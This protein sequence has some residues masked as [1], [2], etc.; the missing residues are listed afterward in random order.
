MIIFE[1][2][3]TCS[4]NVYLEVE[5]EEDKGAF[6][7]HFQ[8]ESQ[9]DL[10][11]LNIAWFLNSTLGEFLVSIACPVVTEYCYKLNRCCRHEYHNILSATS[12]IL[13]LKVQSREIINL[14]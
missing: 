11:N 3:S 1:L 13:C 5:I 12:N 10:E 4:E 7:L 8:G 6:P 14:P 2:L 9:C